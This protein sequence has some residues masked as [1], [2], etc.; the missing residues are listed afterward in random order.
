MDYPIFSLTTDFGLSDEYVGVV[1]G[2]ILSIQPRAQIVDICHTIPPQDIQEA[3]FLFARVFPFFPRGCIHLVIVDPGVGTN[4]RIIAAQFGGSCCIT[5]DNGVLT[6]LFQ[7]FPSA[8]SVHE[9]TN[10]AF[11]RKKVGKTFHGRDIF[12]PVAAYLS[13]GTAVSDLGAQIDV[14]ECVHLQSP[15]LTI[16]GDVLTGEIIHIDH[17]GNLCTNITRNTIESASST[18]RECSIEIKKHR[19]SGIRSTYEDA[20]ASKHRLI[21]LYD[22][23]DHLEIACPNGS[24][25]DYSHARRGDRII[26]RLNQPVG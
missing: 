6:P 21:A 14:T 19:I 9:I 3:S 15:Q 2:Q 18:G 1:K 24:A 4:R 26:V 22:S 13:L 10:S 7:Q 16:D 23:H 25:R 11:F 17:F 12:A 20:S 8:I 5:P